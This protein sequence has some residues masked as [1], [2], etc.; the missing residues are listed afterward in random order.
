MTPR[1]RKKPRLTKAQREAFARELAA[2]SRD[3]LVP[4]GPL[5]VAY[6]ALG[7]APVGDGDGGLY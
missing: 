3:A 4:I 1:K 7:V 6:L 2:F 5:R